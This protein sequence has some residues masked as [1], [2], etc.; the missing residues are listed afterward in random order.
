MTDTLRA[1]HDAVLSSLETRVSTLHFAHAAVSFFLSISLF[2]SAGKLWWD[3][4]TDEPHLALIAG[5]LGGAALLY[6]VTRAILGTK[7]YGREK[8]QITRLLDLRK[9]IGA[10]APLAISGPKT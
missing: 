9:A 6:S 5:S 4:W 8:V 2:G 10:D 1:E 3:H 7:A